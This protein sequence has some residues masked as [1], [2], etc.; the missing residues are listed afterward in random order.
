MQEYR[1]KDLDLSTRIFLGIEMLYP[2]EVRGWGWANELAQEYGISRSLL[3]QFKDRVQEALAAAM[4][5]R[6]VGRPVQD[7]SLVIDRDY[8][9]QAIA[10]M[11]L[12]T[13]SV[14]NIQ[15]G[16]ELLFG[17]QRSIG[18]I[19]QTLQAAGAAAA[20]QNNG[21]CVPLP[22][23][24]E[25]DEIFA[26]RQPCLTV[27][28]G[29]SFLVLNLTAAAGRAATHWGLT[30]LDLAAQGIVFQDL[31][32]DGARGIRAG[33]QQAE[34]AVPLRPDWFHLLREGKRLANRLEKNAYKA[35]RTAEK[36]IR[37]AQEAKQP[38]KRQGR[39]LKVELTPA[40]AI[41]KETQALATY[42]N[43]CW[44]LA[45]VQ[46]A[47]EPITKQQRLQVPEQALQVLETASELFQTLPGKS[48][49]DFAQ[50]LQ[51]H[52]DEL[53]APLHWLYETLIPWCQKLPADLEAW[54]LT[55]WRY[56]PHRLETIPA[57]WQSKATA[58][59]DAFALFQRSS[60]LAES[61]HSWLRPYLTIHRGMPE[62]LFPLLQLFWSHHVFSRG[63]RAGYSP[64]QLAGV[65]NVPSLAG[66]FDNLF[67]DLSLA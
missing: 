23:L 36:A 60:S 31:A 22:V 51:D 17:V 63:K 64:L 41:Q 52:L 1:R 15:L 9:R 18:H 19:S 38:T 67:A 40:E 37:A 24:G 12:L 11:P 13:G 2:A 25:A 39:P 35:M 20:A 21:L 55:S 46:Q 5:P 45:E 7:K 4:K 50:H 16:L 32:A 65:E 10:V 54:I 6:P 26:G 62:W 27:V 34:L 30:C 14:R 44:L 47:L 49:P 42:D 59:W 48:L 58:I 56:D 61:L 28:D 43:C 57:H 53:L 66:A 8:L 33:L 3:Y 29:R